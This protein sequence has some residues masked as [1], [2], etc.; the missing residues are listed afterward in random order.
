MNQ[1]RLLMTWICRENFD[2]N[3]DDNIE[4]DINS[5]R[6]KTISAEVCKWRRYKVGDSQINRSGKKLTG[7][8]SLSIFCH[9]SERL[10]TKYAQKNIR[11][12][13]EIRSCIDRG[14]NVYSRRSSNVIDENW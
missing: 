12:I 1:G 10:S 7:N 11:K 5:N 4:D 14:N 8:N 6:T 2:D 3:L 13:V 9:F